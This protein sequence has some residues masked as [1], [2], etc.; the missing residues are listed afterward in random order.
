MSQYN[1]LSDI[2]YASL[3]Y[4]L[5]TSILKLFWSPGIPTMMIVT[6]E[7]VKIDWSHD[8]GCGRLT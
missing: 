8:L 2:Q 4:C 5:W 3:I 6:L 7:T 1:K